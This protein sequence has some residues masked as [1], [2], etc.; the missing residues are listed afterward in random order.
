MLKVLVDSDGR[1]LTPAI[2][3][4]FMDIF[5]VCD[6]TRMI[7]NEHTLGSVACHP[8][9]LVRLPEQERDARII[10]KYL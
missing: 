7:I 10:H 9:E 8:L 5:F 3:E 6:A 1:G 4:L 2:T